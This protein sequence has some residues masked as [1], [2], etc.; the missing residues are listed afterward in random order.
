MNHTQTRLA[1]ETYYGLTFLAMGAGISLFKSRL[2]QGGIDLANLGNASEDQLSENV[3]LSSFYGTPVMSRLILGDQNSA[4]FNYTDINGNT[5]TLDSITLECCIMVASQEKNIIK[6]SLEGRDGTVKQFI[7]NGDY[8]IDVT[9]IVATVDNNYPRDFVN[10][11]INILSIPDSIP[12]YSDFLNMFGI[13]SVVVENPVI[14]Q[15]EGFYNQQ[16]FT[17]TM[18]SDNPIDL[19][20]VSSKS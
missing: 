10:A 17:W 20:Y 1:S 6:T 19:N 13:N 2:Y 8:K 5:Q 15:E 12:V 14:P 16:K 18:L 4:T 11:L 7:S 3:P 9:V